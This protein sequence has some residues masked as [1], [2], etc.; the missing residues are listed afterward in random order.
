MSI[1]NIRKFRISIKPESAKGQPD[2]NGGKTQ[3]LRTGDIV[4]RQY[5]DGHNI[6]YS[7]LWGMD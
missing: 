7:L 6:I 2:G 1:P 4:R 3:G 5:F